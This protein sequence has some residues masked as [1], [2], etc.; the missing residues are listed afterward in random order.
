MIDKFNKLF[1]PNPPRAT[2][3]HQAALPFEDSVEDIEHRK[4]IARIKNK[5]R[6][7]GLLA[8]G[9]LFAVIA[10]SILS[11]NEYYAVRGA[12]LEIPTLEG[13]P[14]AKVVPVIKP[15]PVKPRIIPS[16][17]VET[18]PP[19]SLT[20]AN[21]VEEGAKL[22]HPTV[23]EGTLEVVEDKKFQVDPDKTLA[24]IVTK[25]TNLGNDTKP[26]TKP[27]VKSDKDAKPVAKAETKTQKPAAKPAD[28]KSEAK[29]AAKTETKASAK[30]EVKAE[31]KVNGPLRASANGRFFIQVIATSNKDAAHR[32][33]Q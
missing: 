17:P 26:A 9:M 6:L 11:P 30:P 19:A 21:R 5:R 12:K 32:R 14:P 8:I 3:M 7:L 13:Q 20:K 28:K 27:A 22:A 15:E 16:V 33:A 29:D 1:G 18:K 10:P 4:N 24:G 23:D 25:T 2:S 31:P